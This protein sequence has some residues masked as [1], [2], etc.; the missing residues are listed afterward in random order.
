MPCLVAIAQSERERIAVK[1]RAGLLAWWLALLGSCASI[2]DHRDATERRWAVDVLLGAESGAQ[3]SGVVRWQRSVRFLVV[4]AGPRL[5]RAVD[6]AFSQLRAAL[7]GLHELSLEHVGSSDVRIGRR[8]YVT[9]FG[10]APGEAGPLAAAHGATPPGRGA[11][12]WFTISWNGAFELTRAL[13]FIDPALELRWL[14]H[15]ALEELYQALGPSN[16]SGLVRD[17]L[18]YERTDDFGSHQRLARVDVEVLQLLYRELAPGAG[19]RAI[20]A[21]MNRSWRFANP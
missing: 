1:R 2:R 10:V 6:E 19:E 11:D 15:T 12:G 18:L 21:A 8:G 3:R 13:V 4:D 17:S 16:D 20:R 14:R 9:V 5:T 7:A